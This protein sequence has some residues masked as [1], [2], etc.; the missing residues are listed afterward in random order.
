MSSQPGAAWRHV[1]YGSSS[2]T[3]LSPSPTRS[4]SLDPNATLAELRRLVD[5]HWDEDS[6]GDPAREFA[7]HVSA[8]DDWLTRGGFLP[9]VWESA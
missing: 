1:A 3:H 2:A 6:A 9:A 8:L 5:E 7:E 4:A